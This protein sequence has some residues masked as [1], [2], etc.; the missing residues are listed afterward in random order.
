MAQ[1]RNQRFRARRVDTRRTCTV[2]RDAVDAVDAVVDAVVV[3]AV[4]DVGRRRRMTRD[5]RRR[6]RRRRMRCKKSWVS[7]RTRAERIAW[8]G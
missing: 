2:K 3:D 8:V 5:P 6:L 1:G 4:E 7:R